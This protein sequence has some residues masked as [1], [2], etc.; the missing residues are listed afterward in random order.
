[1]GLDLPWSIAP[2]L[3]L[4]LYLTLSLSLCLS[5][6]LSLSHPP[7]LTVMTDMIVIFYTTDMDELKSKASL[8]GGCEVPYV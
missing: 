8:Y 6:S 3:S 2:P 5:L 4:L 1:M 7:V